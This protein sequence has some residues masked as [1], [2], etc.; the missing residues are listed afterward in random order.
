MNMNRVAKELGKTSSNR[1]ARA[2]ALATIR[3]IER[4][5]FAVDFIAIRSP[6]WLVRDWQD[7]TTKE[8]REMF[9]LVKVGT[10]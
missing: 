1:K 2:K 4:K 3:D 10:L 7:A 8:R 5:C 6:G 9:G